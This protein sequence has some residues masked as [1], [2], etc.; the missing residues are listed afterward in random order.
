VHATFIVA[1]VLLLLFAACR[2]LL[3]RTIPDGIS[4]ALLA[5]GAAA[6]ACE[7]VS[8]LGVSVLAAGGLFVVLVAAFS[9]GLLGGGDVKL[10]SAMAV[11]LPPAMVWDLV[12]ATAVAGG[13]IAC[14]YLFARRLLTRSG[15]ARRRSLLARFAV[16]EAWRI[17]TSRPMPYAVAIAAGGAAVLI[18][19]F[20]V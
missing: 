15:P 10:M 8:E 6:R 1:A 19:G 20:G 12:F 7:G 14:A 4:V 5:G 9:R 18:P 16:V 17:R 13:V 3:T 11:G 2:D